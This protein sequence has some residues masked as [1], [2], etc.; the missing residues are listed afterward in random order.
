MTLTL[1]IGVLGMLIVIFSKNSLI[2]AIRNN[3]KLVYKL[4]N[5]KWF[6][7]HLLSG[8][9]LFIMN[10]ILFFLTVIILY[11][12]MYLVIPFAHILVM[13][14][15]VI[16]SIFLWIVMNQAWQGTKRNRLKMGIVGSSF[17]VL[18]TVIFL[19]WLVTLKPSYP[20]E[21][22]FMGAI[23]LVFAII[24]SLVAFTTCL[25][26]TGFSKNDG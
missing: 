4:K 17:Y 6:Q 26:I 24:V 16:S 19:F 7:N 12:L 15:A 21:D 20:G 5:A 11:V 10:A 2:D 25:V 9:F 14:L 1:L 13:F 23:G 22:T 18:L 3:N 8:L